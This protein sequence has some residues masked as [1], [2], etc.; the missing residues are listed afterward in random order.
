MT[1]DPFVFIVQL[2]A[3]LQL[4]PAEC[5]V[6]GWQAAIN[7][8]QP[9]ILLPV[10]VSTAHAHLSDIWT[11]P[12]SS[13]AV[14]ALAG[15]DERAT[16]LQAIHWSIKPYR[17]HPDAIGH[18]GITGMT[19]NPF[20]FIVPST[21]TNPLSLPNDGTSAV[22]ARDHSTDDSS[23]VSCSTSEVRTGEDLSADGMCFE[24]EDRDDMSEG[25]SVQ[26]V[27]STEDMPCSNDNEGC[28]SVEFIRNGD[29]VEEPDG[30]NSGDEGNAQLHDAD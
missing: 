22:N 19:S 9:A 28:F 20:V 17:N 30:I 21:P 23:R 2:V 25:A 4:I 11:T 7:A 29:H 27:F 26:D 3:T 5:D 15:L 1:S 12:P 13:T 14:G 24:V 16:A 8:L 18:G 10:N 6:L